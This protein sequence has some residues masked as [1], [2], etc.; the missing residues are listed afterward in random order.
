MNKTIKAV[1]ATL[2]VA[3]LGCGVLCEQAQAIPLP[4]NGSVQF[5]GSAT[6]SGSSPGTPVSVHFNNP[7]HTLNGLGI[8][9]GV[10]SGVTATFNDFTFTGDG[11]LATLGG[12]D[13]PLWNFS[14]GGITYSFDL[15][16]L[17]NGHT[18]PGSMSFS[19]DGIAHATGFA[20][21]FAMV[22]LQGSGTNFAFQIST[23]TTTGIGNVPESGTTLALFGIALVGIVMLRR[24]LSLA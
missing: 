23:S 21:T 4:I 18:E 5:F 6:P 8:Y 3:L 16:H 7:W 10:P 20:D 14:F 1:L 15:M 11:S 2:A 22:A 12:P 9:A 24:Q 13:T 17:S 19:G